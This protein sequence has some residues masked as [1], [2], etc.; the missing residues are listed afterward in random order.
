MSERML[1]SLK[2][3]DEK[4][5]VFALWL[6]RLVFYPILFISL[7]AGKAYLDSHYVSKDYFDKAMQIIS[8][9][10]Q[11]FA[12]EQKQ[13]LKEIKGKLDSL[14]ESSAANAER[15]TDAERRI[16]RLEGISDHR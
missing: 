8:E 14:L 13:D 1:F 11:R 7:Y 15:F 16:S 2:Q 9:E 3:W 12:Q 6:W 5:G 10:K 4:Y